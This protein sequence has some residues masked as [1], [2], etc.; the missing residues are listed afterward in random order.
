VTV[1]RIVPR[2]DC[3]HAE[4]EKADAIRMK[5]RARVQLRAR[6]NRGVTLNAFFSIVLLS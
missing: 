2:N 3:P 6:R 1:P 4:V 5:K